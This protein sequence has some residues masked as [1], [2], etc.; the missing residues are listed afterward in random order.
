MDPDFAHAWD[1]RKRYRRLAWGHA[2]RPRAQARQTSGEIAG[3]L[4]Q[5]YI[6]DHQPSGD[7]RVCD[8]V[9]TMLWEI[10]KALVHASDASDHRD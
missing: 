4:C 6:H 7:V 2:L 9:P 10:K 5:A 1:V 8:A 3:M